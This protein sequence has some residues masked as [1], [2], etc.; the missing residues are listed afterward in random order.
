MKV[1]VRLHCTEPT[2]VGATR[3][4]VEGL[5]GGGRLLEENGRFFLEGPP[6]VAWA[7][8]RQGYVAEV[9]PPL[10][11]RKAL[12]GFSHPE[13]AWPKL[14]WRCSA[15]GIVFETHEHTVATYQKPPEGEPIVAT[16]RCL[17]CD[18]VDEVVVPAQGERPIA[19]FLDP[20][21]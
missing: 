20:R 19:V 5:P 4:A 9:L 14:P 15:C 13:I 8:V 7:C 6:F 12:G 21:K 1:E 18:F 16:F 2:A 11:Q 3:A 10:G 17:P